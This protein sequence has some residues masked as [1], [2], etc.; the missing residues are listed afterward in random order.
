M[1][2]IGVE[3]FGAGD[4]EEDAAQ[5][6][7]A[8]EAVGGDEAC[9]VIRVDRLQHG[10]VLR[11]APQAERADGREPQQHDRPE[12]GADARGPERLDR[13]QRQQD[14]DGGRHHVVV[15]RR[16]GDIEAFERRQHGD[17]RRDRAVA[18]DQRGAEKAEQDDQ[19]TPPLLDA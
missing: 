18:I 12:G 16:R 7:E 10:R 9:A 5:H 11:D 17:R 8:R 2:H 6:Q 13:E 14:D 4:A 19:R 1:A 15:H 3:R